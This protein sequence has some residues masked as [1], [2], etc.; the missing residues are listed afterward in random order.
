M[1]LLG[2]DGTTNELRFDSASTVA[3]KLGMPG[4]AAEELAMRLSHAVHRDSGPDGPGIFSQEWTDGA[5]RWHF[6]TRAR[7]AGRL[8]P[9][10]W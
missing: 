6:I 9:E 8:Q 10:R 1:A 4:I 2:F 7:D 3:A 5:G